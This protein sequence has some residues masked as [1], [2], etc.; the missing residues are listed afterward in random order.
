MQILSSE[1]HIEYIIENV[2]NIYSLLTIAFEYTMLLF[3]WNWPP[4]VT[5][6]S[7][8][9]YGMLPQNKSLDIGAHSS[10]W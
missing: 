2:K 4:Q 1:V 5:F 9:E 8:L 7:K 3:R 6:A 10:L